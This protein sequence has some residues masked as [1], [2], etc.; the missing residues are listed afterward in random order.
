MAIPTNHAGKVAQTSDISRRSGA[1]PFGSH[2]QWELSW[3]RPVI[4]TALLA[5]KKKREVIAIPAIVRLPE[6]TRRCSMSERNLQSSSLQGV[7]Q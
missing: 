2:R 1:A 5:D 3:L 4:G 7:C 6:V